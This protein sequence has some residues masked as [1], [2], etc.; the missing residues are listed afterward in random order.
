MK[1]RPFLIAALAS[2][3]L[4]SPF[5]MAH[6]GGHDDD[7]KAMRII[8]GTYCAQVTKNNAKQMHVVYNSE[9]IAPFTDQFRNF[10]KNIELHWSGGKSL[11]PK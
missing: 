11:L 2:T 8:V 9:Q 3:L 10:P 4:A 5:V 6:P 1:I 7:E